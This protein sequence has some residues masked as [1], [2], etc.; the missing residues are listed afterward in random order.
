MVRWVKDLML[1]LRQS[2]SLLVPGLEIS[3]CHGY[4]PP[5]KKVR[6]QNIPKSSMY[7]Q[8]DA[9]GTLQNRFHR[10][11][12]SCILRDVN[13]GPERSRDAAGVTQS[14]GQG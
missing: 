6:S 3:M 5:P 11:P 4:S 12:T 13:Q 8:H 14:E 1:S 10:I 9:H 2:G 7:S